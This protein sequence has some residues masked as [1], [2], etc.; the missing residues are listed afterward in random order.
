MISPKT[1]AFLRNTL[2]DFLLKEGWH[3]LKTEGF[4]HVDLAKEN[5]NFNFSAHEFMDPNLCSIPLVGGVILSE[6]DNNANREKFIPRIH[7]Y[8]R[9]I[10]VYNYQMEQK[11]YTI[12]RKRNLT[13]F[14]IQSNVESNRIWKTTYSFHIEE[15]KKTKTTGKKISIN[16]EILSFFVPGY[17][18][19]IATIWGE[20]EIIRNKL[21]T[22]I[23]LLHTKALIY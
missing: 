14:I 17:D 21:L 4:L 11:Q 16:G 8:H 23:D 15:K 5:L 13:Q 22:F 19:W 3:L 9:E 12:E 6:V 18:L 7:Q 20:S 10:I 1:P 2:Q